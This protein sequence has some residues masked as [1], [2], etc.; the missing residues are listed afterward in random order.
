MKLPLD[1]QY[2]TL[3]T[4]VL[5]WTIHNQWVIGIFLQENNNNNVSFQVLNSEK[6]NGDTCRTNVG[7]DKKA[8][9]L[10]FSVR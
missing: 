1:S 2:D 3:R 9:Y 6:K 7:K 8:A 10:K 5:K 4:K